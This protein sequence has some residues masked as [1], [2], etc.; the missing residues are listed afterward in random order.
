MVNL[1]STGIMVL[2]GS[3]S[4]W[5]MVGGVLSS[6]PPGG[7]SL[8]AHDIANNNIDDRVRYGIDRITWASVWL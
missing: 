8:T 3:G 6:G 5:I 2:P 1:V 4:T 7:L